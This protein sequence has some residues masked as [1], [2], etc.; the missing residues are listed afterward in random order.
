MN[1]SLLVGA[2]LLQSLIPIL[3]RFRQFKFA[4]S[5]EIEGMFLQVGVK[6]IDQHYL[7]FLWH[8]DPKTDVRIFQKAWD[9]FETRDSPLVQF[10]SSSKPKEIY[11]L[12]LPLSLLYG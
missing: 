2:G 12:Q 5:A 10:M 1:H 4:V 6:P 8:E 7:R 3:L 11:E 9:I